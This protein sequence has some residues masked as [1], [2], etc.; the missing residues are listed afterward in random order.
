MYKYLRGLKTTTR[1]EPICY[2]WA[3]VASLACVG[4]SLPSVALACV[5]RHICH[6]RCLEMRVD[7]GDL[8]QCVT[9]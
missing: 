1:L 5:G 3:L 8:S 9:R 2:C 4:P 7:G 6:R